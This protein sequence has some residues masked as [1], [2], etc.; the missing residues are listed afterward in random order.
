MS[1]LSCHVL[2]PSSETDAVPLLMCSKGDGLAIQLCHPIK[3]TPSSLQ[4]TDKQLQQRVA[5][6]L[7]RLAKP[8]D[9]RECFV[10]RKGLEILLELLTDSRKEASVQKEAAG[11][12]PHGSRL[13]KH[14]QPWLRLS[15]IP[16]GCQTAAMLQ[17]Q[18]ACGELQQS[19]VARLWVAVQPNCSL[20]PGLPAACS[21]PAPTVWV[22]NPGTA[23]LS[24]VCSSPWMG[25]GPSP[26]PVALAAGALCALVDRIKLDTSN[27]IDCQPEAPKP[28][29]GGVLAARCL[30][31]MPA[32]TMTPLCRL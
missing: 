2:L 10:N 14:K 32:P 12:C 8:T 20:A 13:Y 29:V 18:A 3:T 26:L 22:L 5:M 4:A 25:L 17:K 16:C 31:V 30:G 27:V 28:Q 21:L 19:A 9:L 24:V 15:V 23:A 7:A 1:D 6:A 11:G